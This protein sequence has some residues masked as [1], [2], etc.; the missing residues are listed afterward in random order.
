MRGIKSEGKGGR[1]RDRGVGETIG[2]EEE[3][4]CMVEEEEGEREREGEDRGGKEG[5]GG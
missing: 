5:G 1:E 3:Y 4:Q 2:L